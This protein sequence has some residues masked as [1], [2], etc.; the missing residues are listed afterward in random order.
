[1]STPTPKTLSIAKHRS[2]GLPRMAMREQ[3]S[4]CCGGE[5]PNPGSQ[6]RKVAG[7]RSG[8]LPG[9]DM[10]EPWSF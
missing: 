7:H 1:M 5:M 6:I 10:M 4:C 2:R 8:G 9:V 3:S